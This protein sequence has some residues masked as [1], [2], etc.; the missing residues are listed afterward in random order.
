MPITVKVD[1]EEVRKYLETTEEELMVKMSKI[2]YALALK[3]AYYARQ[4]VPVR[5]G[6]LKESIRVNIV[7]D[8]RCEAVAG[9]IE[10]MGKPVNYAVFVEYGT[11]R[12]PGR[13][14]MENGKERTITEMHDIAKR[15]FETSPETPIGVEESEVRVVRE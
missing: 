8:W 12:F 10:V 9:G 2:I 3:C 5:T 6:R 1:V 11:S 13:Y 14:Y 4:V 15:I 7:D